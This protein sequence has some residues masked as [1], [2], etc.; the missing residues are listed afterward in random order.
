MRGS[1]GLALALAA[2]AGVSPAAAQSEWRRVHLEDE[3]TL[4]IP[5]VVGDD[6][7]VPGPSSRAGAT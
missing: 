1:L 6:Y 4:D 3:T 5:A 7:H 2:L